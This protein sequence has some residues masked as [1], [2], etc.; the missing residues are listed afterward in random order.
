MQLQNWGKEAKQPLPVHALAPR[1]SVET[2]PAAAQ[3][4]QL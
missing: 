2:T 1:P 3:L 4:I